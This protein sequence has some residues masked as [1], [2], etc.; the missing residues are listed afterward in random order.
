M[1]ETL[2]MQVDADAFLALTV[3][4]LG[5]NA[6]DET[7]LIEAMRRY[8]DLRIDE[9][10]EAEEWEVEDDPYAPFQQSLPFNVPAGAAGVDAGG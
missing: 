5:L 9:Y 4:A 1:P 2:P 10:L 3:K 8:A 7:F 6:R